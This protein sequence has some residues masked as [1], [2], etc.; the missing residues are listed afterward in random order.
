MRWLFTCTW[1]KS[2]ARHPPISQIIL[3]KNRK[4]QIVRISESHKLQIR[5]SFSYKKHTETERERKKW[6]WL[7]RARVSN[8]LSGSTRRPPTPVSMDLLA[9]PLKPFAPSS[10]PSPL[11]SSM[12]CISRYQ[13]PLDLIPLTWFC[14]F[15]SGP[16][17]DLNRNSSFPD[18]IAPWN[19]N[20]AAKMDYNAILFLLNLASDLVLWCCW[21][22]VLI[23]W[24]SILR[25]FFLAYS[26]WLHIMCNFR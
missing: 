25:W 9:L 7:G 10:T 4:S 23:F 17:I 22:V 8:T 13:P 1:P 11:S 12:L 3:I 14:E 2:Q 26:V 15:R 21:L 16:N 6:L 19:V 24:C 18:R 5:F 20:S